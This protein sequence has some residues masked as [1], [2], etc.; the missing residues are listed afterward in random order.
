MLEMHDTNRGTDFL[1]NYDPNSRSKD[2]RL[3]RD[4]RPVP[5]THADNVIGVL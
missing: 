2:N 5:E 1:K 3:G 4:P